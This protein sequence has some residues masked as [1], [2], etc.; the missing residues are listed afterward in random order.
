MESINNQN[1]IGSSEEPLNMM[2]LVTGVYNSSNL[3]SYIIFILYRPSTLTLTNSL[4]IIIFLAKLSS[5][6][7][8]YKTLIPF[9][10]FL[11]QL[12]SI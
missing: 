2:Q 7:F 1:L 9:R 6:S 4:V 11:A 12:F 5:F 8:I 3:Y 10:L